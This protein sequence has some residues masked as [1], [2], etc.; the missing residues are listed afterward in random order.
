MAVANPTALA[1][2]ADLLEALHTKLD[3]LS[4]EQ[5]GAALLAL[6]DIER[7]AVAWPSRRVVVEIKT[8]VTLIE[9]SLRACL[10][11]TDHA[12][13][14]DPVLP[15]GFHTLDGPHALSVQAH[16]EKLGELARN[17]AQAVVAGASRGPR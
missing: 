10:L 14:H 16:A 5:L 7:T 3:G 6:G 15:D 11:A 12:I 4:D 8:L 2:R 1:I 17:A 13:A 9:D